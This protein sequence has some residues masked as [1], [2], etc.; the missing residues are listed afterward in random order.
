MKIAKAKMMFFRQD[1]LVHFSFFTITNR[2]H[3]SHVVSS[4]ESGQLPVR[5]RDF[6]FVTG[7]NPAEIAK[8]LEEAALKML[9]K[10]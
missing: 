1:M 9:D 4:E 10:R 2:I 8:R 5:L 7:N 6:S 3:F